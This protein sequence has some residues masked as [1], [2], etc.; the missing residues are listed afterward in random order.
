MTYKR[1]REEAES[2]KMV[3]NNCVLKV[4]KSDRKGDDGRGVFLIYNLLIGGL[5]DGGREGL[6]AIEKDIGASCKTGARLCS[7]FLTTEVRKPYLV[8]VLE[9]SSFDNTHQKT[10]LKTQ[11]LFYSRSSPKN[12]F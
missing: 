5:V 10:I 2:A 4:I 1:Y 8:T 7:S 9:S 11:A 3:Y 6:E 12:K